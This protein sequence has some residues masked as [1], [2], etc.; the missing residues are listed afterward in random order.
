MTKAGEAALREFRATITALQFF[1]EGLGAALEHAIGRNAQYVLD[2]EELA[3][4]IEQRQSEAG[5][6]AQLDKHA[7]KSALQSRHDP[8]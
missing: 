5:I 3:E 4:L 2:S 6:A 1:L 8:Q 7:G